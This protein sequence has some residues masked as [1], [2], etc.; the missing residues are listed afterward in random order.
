MPWMALAVAWR[1]RP[2]HAP[3]YPLPAQ[4]IPSQVKA[5]L[6]DEHG[7]ELSQRNA[8]FVRNPLL[9]PDGRIEGFFSP[10]ATTAFRPPVLGRAA[11]TR[12]PVLESVAV[13]TPSTSTSSPELPFD[14]TTNEVMQ[15]MQVASSKQQVAS[16]K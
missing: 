9:V 14:A 4:T 7:P 15:V 1:A 3:A 2:P 11:N 13:D 10:S 6:D 16:S 12:T 8:E 5:N